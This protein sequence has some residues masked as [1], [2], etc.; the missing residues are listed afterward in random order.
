MGWACTEAQAAGAQAQGTT[1]QA[2]GR[3]KGMGAGLGGGR[4][5]GSQMARE[6]RMVQGSKRGRQ[7]HLEPSTLLT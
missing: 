5:G 6:E 1:S 7:Q 3:A 4:R 2:E